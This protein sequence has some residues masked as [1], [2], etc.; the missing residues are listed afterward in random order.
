MNV[1]LLNLQI[2]EFLIRICHYPHLTYSK[3]CKCYKN[4]LRVLFLFHQFIQELIHIIFW[5]LKIMYFI[6]Y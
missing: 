5:D 3:S 4:Q 2:F 6:K 1:I